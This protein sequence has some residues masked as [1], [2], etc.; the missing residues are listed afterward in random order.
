LISVAEL[1]RTK[2][3]EQLKETAGRKSLKKTLGALDITL[4]GIGAIIGAGIFVLTGVAA[5]NYAGP[6]IVLSFIIS[7]IACVLVALIYSELASMIPVAGSTYTYSYAALGEIIAWVVGWD[8][9]LEYFFS[10]SMV[11]TGWSGY[12]VSIFKSGGIIL[13]QSLTAAPSDG[14]LIN[15]PAMLIPLFIGL[16]L[17]KGTRESATFNRIIVAIKLLAIFIFVVLAAPRFDA[18]NW[19]P[20]LP[21]GLNGVL[22]G[23]AIIFTAYLGFDAISTTA[24][25]TKNPARDLPI[26]IIGSLLICTVLYIVVSALLTGIVPYTQLNNPEPVAYAL[27]AVGYRLGAAVVAVGA[28]AGIT[29][30]L[31]V[32]MYGQTRIVFAMSRDGFLPAWVSSLHPKYGTPYLVTLMMACA[33]ALVAGLVPI[34]VLAELVNIGTLFAFILSAIGVFILRRKMPGLQRP[35]KCPAIRIVAPL[36]VIMCASLMLML[37]WATWL[38]FALWFCLGLLIY[39]GY[40]YRHSHLRKEKAAVVIKSK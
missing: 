31:L 35:F 21:F 15:L 19:M 39:F 4:M 20:F 30:V 23:A 40:G 6:G 32:S 24:E 10:I 17:V 1:F 37:P 5:A 9:I 38:R 26:G 29:T 7:G 18:T 3:V 22:A 16:L 25:E 28:I 11:A 2:S 36:A 34:Q 8:L 13:P 12:M 27:S 14:G 33:A